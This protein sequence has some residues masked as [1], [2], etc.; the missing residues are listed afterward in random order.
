[1]TYT[2]RSMHEM[3][4]PCEPAVLAVHLRA[5]GGSTLD[6][7]IYVPWEN[8]CLAYAYV[9]TTV[10]EGNKG[11]VEIDLELNAAS[12]TEIMSI[13]VAQNAA[14]GD[15]DEASF[16]SGATGEQAGQNLNADVAAR[17]AIN[18]EL[19]S[20][21]ATTWRGTLFMYFEPWLSG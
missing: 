3:R 19:A 16:T 20:T 18:I 5:V 17:D 15:I 11:T 13:Q 9:V 1:M 14:V 21:A 12:G 6:L 4:V 10:A 7:P 8:C 2:K